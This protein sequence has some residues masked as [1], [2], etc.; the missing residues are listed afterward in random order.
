[1]PTYLQSNTQRSHPYIF[2]QG[3]QKE[4]A[5]IYPISLAGIEICGENRKMNKCKKKKRKNNNNKKK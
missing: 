5:N 4:E 3:N 1:M 2:K